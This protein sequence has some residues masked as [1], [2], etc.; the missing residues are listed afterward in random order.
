[1]LHE[2]G[3]NI[4]DLYSS[5]KGM[6]QDIGKELVQPDH[7]YYIQNIMPI[8]L[9]EGQVRY[10]NGIFSSAPQD[11][12]VNFFPFESAAGLKQQ[13]IYMNGFQ[14][15]ATVSNLTVVSSNHIRLTSINYTLFQADTILQLRYRTPTG[16]SPVSYYEINNVT[17]VSANT[18]DIEVNL[19]SFPDD[20]IDFFIIAP[21]TVAPVY[22]SAT[23]FSITVPADFIANLTYVPGQLLN[24]SVNTV[25]TQLTLSVVDDTV[26]GTINFTCVGA[27]VPNFNGGDTLV[28]SYNSLTPQ[29]TTISNAYGYIKVLDIASN[30]L[31]T[32]GT[33]T[34]TNLSVACIPRAEF[35]GQ[36]L[37]I[38]NGVNPIMT[39]DG[40]LLEVYTESVKEQ[41]QSFNRID[42]THFSFV[43]NAS[44][45]I[46]KYQGGNSIT[47]NVLG[48]GSITTIVVAV[49]IADNVVTIQTTDNIPAFTGANRVEV[50]YFD[51]PPPFSYM[52]AANDRLW[53]LGVGAV[54]LNYRIPEEAMR[55]YYAY[56]P[57]ADVATF[58]FFNE[59]TKTVP[60]ED[61]SA[62][63]GG[64]DN[65]E[66]IVSVSGYLAF[67][68][69]NKT[70]IW[71]GN[72]PLTENLSNSFSWSSTIPVGIFHGDL[73]VEL[74]NDAYFFSESGFVSFST[75]NIAKQFGA[76]S[77]TNMNKIA[78]E[79]VG[80]VNTDIAYRACRSFKYNNG[81]FC[82][83][84]I[85][86]N[87]LI[88]SRFHTSLFWWCVFSGDF[89][90]SS[91]FIS[92]LDG[93]LYHSINN[94]I[95][96]YAD[97]SN[98]APLL[99]GDNN[100]QDAITFIETKYIN[101][102]K[103]RFSNKRYEIQ[104]DYSSSVLV[105]PGN[106]INV[107]IRGDLSSSFTLQSLF[108]FPYSIKVNLDGGGYQK[109]T[110]RA[111]ILG[112]INLA[113]GLNQDDN[114]PSNKLLG[115]HLDAST[116]TVKGRLQFLSSHFSL[117]L[118]G[119]TKDGPFSLKRIRLFGIL[120]R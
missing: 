55:V 44:F 4:I 46:K 21:N 47:L 27:A 77:T 75:F 57:Y 98:S 29:I 94:Q 49:A 90:K 115:F 36:K 52:K 112:T 12:I 114:N 40:V 22:I 41:A 14:N 118:V 119:H 9:G 15:F 17:V 33:Q 58:R 67:I 106:N 73:V 91:A 50:F 96:Q 32:G 97:G 103:N 117:S 30:A 51:K 31:L 6:N 74:A 53:C 83:F 110:L 99:Y 61:L 101:N 59:N 66:A 109:N 65:L 82:G 19:N 25:V 2:A 63:Q 107:Y 80:T 42:N 56:T 120:E 68:G 64:A 116:Q 62:K 111:D 20:L 18:I 5:T 37:W 38:Y 3:Y 16:L 54:G 84:K 11:R 87:N 89:S 1:M 92:T 13:V 105:N 72:D 10:G 71:T 86:Q 23:Q 88:V 24:L 100:G 26:P 48:T 79:Y 28:L 43:S 70:Q 34:L 45:D 102:I 35:F 93:S 108:E 39:W 85:G 8:S 7:S 78:Q 81:G 60:S 95:Y 69:R 104:C 76:T 113:S